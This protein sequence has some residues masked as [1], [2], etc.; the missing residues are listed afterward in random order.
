M[1]MIIKNP[2]NPNKTINIWNVET[3][4]NSHP[5][6]VCSSAIKDSIDCGLR[7]DNSLVYHKADYDKFPMMSDEDFDN[8]EGLEL[9]L[10]DESTL[11]RLYKNKEIVWLIN[12]N[13]KYDVVNRKNT[14]I[15]HCIV[16]CYVYRYKGVYTVRNINGCPFR[17]LDL[18]HEKADNFD[19]YYK[20]S[21]SYRDY[22]YE[23]TSMGTYELKTN[24]DEYV[25]V[26]TDYAFINRYRKNVMKKLNT[27][28]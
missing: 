6:E 26:S 12:P 4:M 14:I 3:A 22:K 9:D 24:A 27:M 1:S 23:K 19:V 2:V 16:A 8:A 10:T 17:Y 18:F 20:G 28:L 13:I 21:G 5:L 11:E 15:N 25:H 7:P